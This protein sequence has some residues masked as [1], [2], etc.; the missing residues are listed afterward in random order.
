MHVADQ[1]INQD[2]TETAPGD[3]PTVNY[4]KSLSHRQEAQCYEAVLN[5]HTH[6]LISDPQLGFNL[7]SHELALQLGLQIHS[8]KN[9]NEAEMHFSE[10]N[11][12]LSLG[13]VSLD[14]D[15]S[16]PFPGLPRRDKRIRVQCFVHRHNEFCAMIFGISTWNLAKSM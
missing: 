11:V 15:L 14:W 2:T 5:G 4:L 10:S 9:Q 8:A 3:T 16:S 13:T 6:T 12:G 1:G 7:I